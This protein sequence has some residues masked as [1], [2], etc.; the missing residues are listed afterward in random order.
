VLGERTLA[1]GAGAGWLVARACE[2][3]GGFRRQ[4]RRA[5]SSEQALKRRLGR[6]QGQS[7]GTELVAGAGSAG[8]ECTRK[9]EC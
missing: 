6:A 2:P 9:L 7:A 1:A 3:R 4:H 8:H 5:S